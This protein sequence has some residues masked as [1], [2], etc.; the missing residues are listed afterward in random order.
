[1]AAKRE[2]AQRKKALGKRN[3]STIIRDIYQKS[4]DAKDMIRKDTGIVY[5]RSMA[6]HR[7]LWDDNYPECPERFT[8]VLQRCE[9]LGLVKRCKYI[10]PRNAEY[11]ELLL[12]H[13]P[14]HIEKLK[15]TE[16]NNDLEKLE[17]LA[18]KYDAVYFHPVSKL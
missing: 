9:E 17:E 3:S 16:D 4:I 7:C 10:T 18:S 8:R 11:N 1:M 12:K 13:T 6:E 14:A 15:S 2:A 5:D